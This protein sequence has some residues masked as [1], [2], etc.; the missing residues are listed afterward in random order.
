MI[1]AD[2]ADKKDE[3][4]RLLEE[5]VSTLMERVETMTRELYSAQK[6]LAAIR[7][8]TELR[9]KELTQMEDAQKKL[10]G[11]LQYK[12]EF[13]TLLAHELRNPLT[14]IIHSVEILKLT[15]GNNKELTSIIDT[16]ER[17][18][19]NISLILKNL[20]DASRAARGKISL[21]MKPL[22]IKEVIEHAIGTT[23]PL[24][25][26]SG[27]R[28]STA[29]LPVRVDIVADPTRLEQVFV[30]LLSNAI[31]YTPHGGE[32]SVV[33]LQEAD[34]ILVHIK[35]NGIGIPSEVLP[36]IFDLFMQANQGSVTRKGGLGIG[37]M[38]ARAFT[39]LQGG[40]LSV[41]S[42]GRDKGSRFTV[43]LPILGSHGHAAVKST[44]GQEKSSE[45]TPL[46]IKR[47]LLIDDNEKLLETFQKLL[48]ALGQNVHVANNAEDA[49]REA[50]AYIPEVVFMDISMPDMEGY[51][52]V[53]KLKEISSLSQTYFV[54]LT[55]L[56][57]RKIIQKCLTAGFDQHLLK[58]IGAKEIK[59]VLRKNA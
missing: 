40:T 52:L 20:L 2:K 10:E 29:W 34:C 27:N 35:D 31:K 12:D 36:Y 30:N 5:E 49:I 28:L 1:N 21:N 44:R 47:V 42:E 3:R 50:S 51:E 53:K 8:E 4:T 32:I 17:Q 24:L 55:G 14:P 59:A 18:A 58:P 15:H 38:L 45:E 46:P 9:K 13:I 11:K 19:K 48:Q 23:K 7:N 57:D 37:L 25:V 22:D 39:E 6:Q 26:E 43:R 16:I 56:G 41:E 54:A 33:V